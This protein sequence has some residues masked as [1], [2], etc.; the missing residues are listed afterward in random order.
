AYG[1]INRLLA[2]RVLEARGLID[3]TLRQNPDYD[4]LSEAL[5]VLRQSDPARA[6]GPDGGWWAVIEDACAAQAAALPGLFGLDSPSGASSAALYDP[7][8]ALRPSTTALLRCVELLAGTTSVP[9][10]QSPSF[11]MRPQSQGDLD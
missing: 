3:E 9:R 11:A 6:S 8:I 7:A 10:P 4:G 5:Y 1:W 2:L